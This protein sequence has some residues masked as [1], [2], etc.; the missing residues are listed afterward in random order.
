M[1]VLSRVGSGAL[2]VS[3]LT[4]LAGG[5]VSVHL[6]LRA[7]TGSV[8]VVVPAPSSVAWDREVVPTFVDPRRPLRADSGRSVDARPSLASAVSR[9]R[10]ASTQV[11]D[12]ARRPARPTGAPGRPT[13]A[14][15][16]PGAPAPS[17]PP[18]TPAPTPP[19]PAAPAPPATPAPGGSGPAVQPP[20]Q[21]PQ[22]SPRPQPPQTQPQPPRPQ[23]T[24]SP[25]RNPP[26]KR[27][28]HPRATPAQPAVP[29][30]RQDPP[31]TPAATPA[32]PAIPP[33]HAAAHENRPE[34]DDRGDREKPGKKP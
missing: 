24:P 25:P 6:W 5:V 18:A 2:G 4:T 19:P 33:P 21:P 22:P 23:P 14:P 29:P 10:P 3:A 30:H 34:S 26:L 27:D 1:S 28:G 11:G 9:A 31:G 16:G 20:S 7:L 8:D 15:G 32:V 17:P 12:R 13:P